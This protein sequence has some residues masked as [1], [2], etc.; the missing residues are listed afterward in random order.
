MV[1]TKR[2][3]I[4]TIIT[5]LD[6]NMYW[7]CLNATSNPPKRS[8]SSL[9][10]LAYIEA[11]S[12]DH[13][14]ICTCIVQYES[15]ETIASIMLN[16]SSTLFNKNSTKQIIQITEE[17][18]R[19]LEVIINCILSATIYNQIGRNNSISIRCFFH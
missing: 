2:I 9:S 8:N 18:I 14:E 11:K 5:P 7:K 16:I 17:C 10:I 1:G 19:L 6:M 13:G 4:C 15:F 3:L 12:K